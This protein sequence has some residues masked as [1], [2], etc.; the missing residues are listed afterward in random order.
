MPKYV[1][2]AVGQWEMTCPLCETLVRQH[3]R[4]VF[5]DGNDGPVLNEDARWCKC[6]ACD[7][8][9][10]WVGGAMV[11][12]RRSHA[13]PPQDA[14]PEDVKALYEEARSIADLSPR[15]AAALLRTALETLTRKHLGQ[16]G[17]LNEAIG[18]L[19]SAGK[20]DQ[21]LQQAMDL[22]RITGNGSVH[23]A[24]LQ[25]DDTSA[26]ASALFEI[27]NLIVE[28][29]VAQPNRIRQLYGQLPEAQ[30]QQVERRDGMSAS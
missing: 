29:L 18:D 7:G 24:E 27:L 1:A 25:P 22:V 11:S 26:T 13:Q 4:K 12:P 6:G 30:L 14:M 16:K 19:V 8:V 9:S 2:S 5:V 20:I 28:R 15:S 3:W 23:P 17:R 21:S 10:W